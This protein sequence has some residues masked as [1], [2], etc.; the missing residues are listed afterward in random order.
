MQVRR[1]QVISFTG[2]VI[3][4]GSSSIF[5]PAA[6]V[7]N[8]LDSN[9]TIVRALEDSLIVDITDSQPLPIAS[10]LPPVGPAGGDLTG[11][12][13][14]PTIAQKGASS[15][16]VLT[17]NGSTWAPAPAGSATPVGPAGGDL[18]GSYP[19]PT[20]S[21]KG[22]SNGQVLSWNGSAWTPIS[23]ATTLPPS[24]PAGG[25]L[26]G[27]Y[28]NP[29]IAQKGAVTGQGLF[30]N[31]AA[32]TPGSPTPGGAAG[33]DLD[34]TYPNPILAQKG[35]TVGQ[36]MSWNGSAWVPATPSGSSNGI[37]LSYM[38]VNGSG[39]TIGQVV[40]HSTATSRAVVLAT[41]TADNGLARVIG[42][43][44]DASIA[45]NATG[46]IIV[47]GRSTARFLAGLTLTRNDEVFLST[48]PGSVTN[49]APSGLG[50]VIQSLGVITDPLTYDG[51]GDLLAEIQVIRGAK[52][53]LS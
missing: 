30:W 42:I 38:N 37:Q 9:P 3:E 52:A 28:P 23:L 51:V 45:N 18:A 48:T 44:S 11:F 22:A 35:A 29:T 26:T 10:G 19:N 15:G 17:W 50:N 8:E 4:A 6:S 7:F 2:V 27:T 33:G 40:S 47:E 16:E 49:I 1:Y 53:V 43:V 13:P 12:Y 41:A 39:I 46:N 25:D 32:W 31:G 21:Q 5:F 24:G 36:I 20:I 14:N 34:G